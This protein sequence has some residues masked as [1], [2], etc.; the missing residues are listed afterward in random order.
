MIRS[1]LA[2][3]TKKQSDIHMEKDASIVVLHNK[4][5]L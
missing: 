1:N 5:T 4:D 2:V 3:I